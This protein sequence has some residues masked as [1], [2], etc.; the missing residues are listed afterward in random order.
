M[1]FLFPRIAFA[2][3]RCGPVRHEAA[4]LF[5]LFDD[6]FNE[7]QRASQAA[8]KQFNPRFD[9]KETKEAYSLEGELPGI[10]QK[11]LNIE[12]TDEHTLVIKGRTERQSE[13]GRR[14]QAVEA[15][16]KAAIE[17]TSANSESGSVK[18]HRPTVEDEEPAN[19][20]AA[21]ENE[22]EVA[23]STPTSAEQQVGKTEEQQPEQQYWITER[24]VGEFTRSFSFPH[25]VNQEAVK[26][27]LKN[28]ILSIVVPKAPAPE[29]RRIAIE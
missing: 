2:P 11:D 14:P 28:G 9:L 6:T 16:Q 10:D 1:S 4:P 15:E 12:F 19:S 18:S 29:S 3:V 7:L 17:G 20:S 21:T 23:S 25:R 22:T 26:A 13:S 27:S 24:H 5:S 8:R